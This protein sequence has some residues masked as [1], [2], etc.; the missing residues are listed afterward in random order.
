M[1][2]KSLLLFGRRWVGAGQMMDTLET[3]TREGEMVQAVSV[4]IIWT[5]PISVALEDR[6]QAPVL[7]A[8]LLFVFSAHFSS[9]NLVLMSPVTF[10]VLK[11]WFLVWSWWFLSFSNAGWWPVASSS[12][13][14]HDKASTVGLGLIPGRC[15]WA[16]QLGSLPRTEVGCSSGCDSLVVRNSEPAAHELI[17]SLGGLWVLV[18]NTQMN[19]PS[20]WKWGWCPEL[21]AKS[22][23]FFPK[24]RYNLCGPH[25]PTHKD[26][27]PV[28]D[29]APV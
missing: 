1:I 24:G 3:K 25:T 11:Q 18:P 26:M 7:W 21:L 23:S 12:S 8:G 15:H 29:T 9:Q 17:P 13:T 10:G 14:A 5:N 6:G 19:F 28:L 20:A 22:G 4:A 16:L 27:W 2:S